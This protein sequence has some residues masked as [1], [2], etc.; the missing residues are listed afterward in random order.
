M[1][2]HNLPEGPVYLS[3]M[4]EPL[5]R[6]KREKPVCGARYEAA[7]H[8]PRHTEP[9]HSLRWATLFSNLRPAQIKVGRK[10]V[11]PCN[12]LSSHGMEDSCFGRIDNLLA[13]ADQ[14]SSELSILSEY[15]P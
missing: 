12:S 4:V 6:V 7:K 11:L 1:S 3:F 13:A 2:L 15:S 5:A 10:K 14:P 9:E 8:K